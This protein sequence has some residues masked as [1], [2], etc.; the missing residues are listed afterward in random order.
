VDLGGYSD[1]A[2]AMTRHYGRPYDRRQIE[3]WNRR[4]TLNRYGQM[5]P[6]PARVVPHA[7][8]RQP[9]LLFRI[10]DVIEWAAAGIPAPHG[11]GWR[12]PFEMPDSSLT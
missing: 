5:F 7:L 4:R 11:N 9:R 6:S 1:V 3:L 2:A 10:R 8:P 12:S